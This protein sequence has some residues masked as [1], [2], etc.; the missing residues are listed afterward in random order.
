MQLGNSYEKCG[1]TIEAYQVLFKSFDH[2]LEEYFDSSDKYSLTVKFCFTQ[3]FWVI[4]DIMM[5]NDK[6]EGNGQENTLPRGRF[7][8]TR[9]TASFEATATATA[10]A[11]ITTATT[12]SIGGG[13][14]DRDSGILRDDENTNDSSNVSEPLF[15]GHEVENSLLNSPNASETLILHLENILQSLENCL[16]DKEFGLVLL[17]KFC[18]EHVCDELLMF[19]KEYVHFR[20]ALNQE[21]RNKIGS[22]IITKFIMDSAR[23]YLCLMFLFISFLFCCFVVFLHN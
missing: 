6:I 9:N 23:M 19:Y 5:Q 22:K 13:D 20:D 4:V 12:I 7:N 17:E 18:H 11:T 15:V 1:F 8:R 10:T 16:S 2:S 21:N 3:V 14:G